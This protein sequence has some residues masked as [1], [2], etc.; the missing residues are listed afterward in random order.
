MDHGPASAPVLAAHL[1]AL[2]LLF[3]GTS[4]AHNGFAELDN[5]PA[6][7]WSKGSYAYYRQGQFAA[8]AGIEGKTEGNVFFAGEHTAPYRLRGTMN[9]AVDSG[10]RV[11][12]A[13]RRAAKAF[14]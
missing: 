12:K 10:E 2:D 5:W 8:F 4:A 6:D 11:A 3:P 1:A 9:G 7:P 14:A 13:L